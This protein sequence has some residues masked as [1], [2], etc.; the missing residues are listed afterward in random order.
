MNV[1]FRLPAV[2]ALSA[3]LLIAGASAAP[4]Q[5]DASSAPPKRLS[6]EFTDPLTTLPQF[7]LQDAYTPDNHGTQ[8]QTNKVIGRL[9]VPRVPRFSLFP[10]VQ[11]IR[12]S[13]SVVT[14]PTTHARPRPQ[15]GAEPA[16]RTSHSHL[17]FEVNWG[18]LPS[19]LAA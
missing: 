4:A 13:F 1:L 5:I 19:S 2:A 6:R 7:F 12:P 16:A 14:V 10:L 11:L 3:G 9:I 15:A 18:A 17:R 8:A